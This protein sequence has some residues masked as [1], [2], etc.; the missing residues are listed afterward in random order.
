MGQRLLDDKNVKIMLG[1]LTS[2]GGIQNVTIRQK[3]EYFNFLEKPSKLISSGRDVNKLKIDLVDSDGGIYHILDTF[4]EYVTE[5][6]REFEIPVTQLLKTYLRKTYKAGILDFGKK[7]P[8]IVIVSYH[9]G[10]AAT[11]LDIYN[12]SSDS[13]SKIQEILDKVNS[14]V[15]RYKV[16]LQQLEQLE[17]EKEELEA[18]FAVT[19]EI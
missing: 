14:K 7:M 10:N 5:E 12:I 2:I 4:R 3:E 19:D 17:R 6:N 11:Y 13:K 16:V 18:A 9:I 8:E 15:A 1:V